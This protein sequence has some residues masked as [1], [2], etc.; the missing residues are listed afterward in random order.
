MK[1][2]FQLAFLLCLSSMLC[3][4]LLPSTVYA[5]EDTQTETENEDDNSPKSDTEELPKS[6]NMAPVYHFSLDKFLSEDE[7][8]NATI[9]AENPNMRSRVTFA[10]I[11]CEATKYEGL[12]YV[13]GGRYPS[14]GGFDCAGLCMYVYNQVCGTN[15]DLIYTN[16]A[17]LYTNHCTPVSESEAKPGDLVFFKGT[18]QS[19]DYIS[20]V[21]IYC[22]NGV[23]FNAGD[24]IGYGYVHDVKNM[25][26]DDAEVL[27]G[28]VNGVSVVGST[29]G[30][31]NL[32]G[33]WY[34]FDENGNQTIGWKK[35]NNKYYYFNDSGCMV[36]GW[37]SI[38]GTYYYFDANGAMQTGWILNN[39]Y[40]LNTNG[41]M[42]TGW[43]KINDVYYYFNDSGLKVTNRWISDYYLLEDGKM[44]QNQWIGNYYVDA[45]GRWVSSLRA[46]EWK[47]VD[48]KDRCY[49][50]ISKAFI[51]NELKQIDGQYY[52][53][54]A[55]GNMTTGFVTIGKNKY[56][57]EKDGRM[58]TSWKQIDGDYYFF[59]ASGIMKTSRWLGNYYLDED[60]KMLTNTM[61]PDGRYVD[62]DGV[63]A[64]NRWIKVNDK[65]Y[66]VD[67]NGKVVK[68]QWIGDSYLDDNGNRVTNK[69]VGAYYLNEDGKYVKNTLTPDG[70]YCGSDGV[71]LTSRW[72]K[73]EG[74]DYYV[75]EVGKVLKN[76]WVG[77]YYLGSAGFML[78]N[79]FTPDGY[80]VGANGAWSTSKW[81][82]SNNQWWYRHYDG[83]YTKN[84]FETI[85]NQTY[86]FDKNGYMVT[87]WKLIDSDWYYFNANGA[88][89]KNSWFGNYYL[90]EDGKMATNKWIDKDYVGADGLWSPSRWIQ[91][92]SQWWYR[93]YDGTYTKN[94]F[95]KIGNQTYYFDK[96]GYMV[97]GWQKINDKKYY[98]N[99]S[100]AMV[101]NAWQGNYYLG[102]DGSMLTNT[103]TPDKFYV[104]MDGAWIH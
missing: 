33:N 95:E 79:T 85:G 24:P 58:V 49:S 62:K 25:N 94:G 54:D 97:T 91:L 15:F 10:D 102:S 18:Y 7:I 92:G 19:I 88:M 31:D 60:G 38:S 11:L 82:Q 101:M 69:W 29:S 77:N 67:G 13:W 27:F 47:K 37:N 86:Y 35:I 26:G 87:G 1:H 36:T 17:M 59:D 51:T 48:G 8:E 64:T 34:Y 81:V 99:N 21:G 80:Y 12:P 14:Q 52:Y 9:K 32:N 43:Q 41:A 90:E 2:C 104:G 93:H 30:W 73:Y 56:Y 50:N 57:F 53:F 66:Y 78:T 22:G 40:Y 16:A 76:T 6:S 44:A 23:M 70:Y 83:T 96:N 65:D 39:S 75:N 5:Q 74:K 61:T 100:G 71:Y 42:L 3:V 103:M 20:H 4:S 28:R 72:F 68:N 55:D 45:N 98:F 84:D 63:R 89:I 46:Y